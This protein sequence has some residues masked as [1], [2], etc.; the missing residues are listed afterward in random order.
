MHI[1]RT[2]VFATIPLGG[3]TTEHGLAMEFMASNYVR[4]PQHAAV[5]MY[6]T[7]LDGFREPYGRL[8]LEDPSMIEPLGQWEICVN[9]H[10]IGSDIVR[11]V[12]IASGMFED[13]GRK[14]GQLQSEVW[15]ILPHKI[16]PQAR[17]SLK[18]AFG[19][20]DEP[21]D[22]SRRG[23]PKV[24]AKQARKDAM[25]VNLEMTPSAE[26]GIQG[27]IIAVEFQ[28]DSPL[29]AKCARAEQTMAQEDFTEVCMRLDAEAV[30]AEVGED[31]DRLDYV[32]LAVHPESVQVRA[33]VRHGSDL[34]SALVRTDLLTSYFLKGVRRLVLAR[35][36]ARDLVARFEDEHRAAVQSES[37]A[38]VSLDNPPI[39]G[40]QPDTAAEMV[41][42]RPA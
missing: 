36:D 5:Q 12:A 10:G 25:T 29:L 1:H 8:T 33:G 3:Y 39:E 6:A 31:R 11:S 34:T 14:V 18:D 40:E 13:T 7:D 38:Y 22:A 24:H 32:E 9:A 4:A 26:D 42:P 23:A 19:W 28:F 27:S 21:Q 41:R 16:S 2:R 35:G 17:S 30:H 37:V 15:R 20:H